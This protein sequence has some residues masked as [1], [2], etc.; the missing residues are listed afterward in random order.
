MF[1]KYTIAYEFN[2]LS[3]GSKLASE[4]RLKGDKT[5]RDFL[6]DP[7]V[8]R[9]H[10]EQINEDTISNIIDNL[11]SKT[12]SGYDSISAK[13]LKSMKPVI[14]INLTTIVN[15]SLHSGIFPEN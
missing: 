4:I 8:Y 15:Q 6:T 3:I 2:S 13:L 11:K 1:D 7:P 14:L 12:S 5:Y 9:F 10:F